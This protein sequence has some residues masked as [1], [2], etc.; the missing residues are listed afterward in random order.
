[1][2]FCLGASRRHVGQLRFLFLSEP[3]KHDMFVFKNTDIEKYQAFLASTEKTQV[4][5][6]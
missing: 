3:L 6:K 5:A 1:M 2:N 4:P